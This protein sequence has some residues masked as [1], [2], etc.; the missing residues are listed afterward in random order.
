M[1]SKKKKKRKKERKKETWPN[2]GILCLIQNEHHRL[3][4]IKVLLLSQSLA[5]KLSGV[6]SLW[7]PLTACLTIFSWWTLKV[8]IIFEPAH[9]KTYKMAW[10]PIEDSDQPGHL[11]SLIW[12]FAVH[13]KK[14][15]VL[16]YRLSTQTGQ[17]PLL[18]VHAILLVLS[19]AGSFHICAHYVL[20]HFIFNYGGTFANDH[21]YITATSL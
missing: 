4:H 8:L 16:S 2:C 9:D 6:I 3:I 11:P 12:V 21:L 14:A 19:Y 7:L 5:E 15:W 10:V 13:M 1:F 20:W 18:S 17:M